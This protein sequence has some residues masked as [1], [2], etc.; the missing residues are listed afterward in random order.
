[1]DADAPLKIVGVWGSGRVLLFCA[2]CTWSKSYPVERI[3]SRM[4]AR[5][6]GD[7]QSPASAVAKH[8]QWPCPA[9]G[10]MRW[11]S[12]PAR[13]GEGAAP[14]TGRRAR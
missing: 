8:V 9:C 11:G 12:R 1:M 5:G 7:A 10:R 3:I 13:G 6:F 2:S 14:V 4:K